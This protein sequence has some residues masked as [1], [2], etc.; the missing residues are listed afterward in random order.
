MDHKYKKFL[1]NTSLI[2]IGNAGSKLLSILL[3]PFYTRWLSVEDYGLT[4]ILSVY[5]TL[6]VSVVSC[7]IAE[8]LFVFP[9]G[10]DESLQKKY[11]SSGITFALLMLV[12]TAIVFILLETITNSLGLHNSFFDNYWLIYGLVST[13]ILQSMSQQIARSL[14]KMFIY[15]S[16]GLI[17][18]GATAIF[19]FLLIPKYG[20]IGFVFSIIL[21]NFTAFLYSFIFSKNYR[22]I[23][24]SFIKK[25]ICVE[26]LRYSIPLIP[27]SIMWWLI[28]AFNRPMMEKSLGLYAVG[29]YAIANKFPSIITML[30]NMIGVSWQNSVLE[31]Y[32]KEGFDKFYDKVFSYVFV[33]FVAAFGIVSLSSEF[34]VELIT[35]SAYYEAWHYIPLLTI[36]VVFANMSGISSNIFS[37]VKQSKYYF[38]STIWGGIATILLNILF[39][40][41]IGLYGACLSVALSFA[42]MWLA[43]LIYSWQF[44][45]LINLRNHIET[46]IISLLI[47]AASFIDQDILRIGSISL[48]L[49]ILLLRNRNMFINLLKK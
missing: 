26:M 28:S 39:I 5:Q 24:F 23:G 8:S 20:V 36:A 10:Q 6:L 19:S 1:R 29:I 9:K 25:D 17:L 12:F 45:K 14:D 21:A 11:I 4:D 41:T 16:T 44:A 2:F 35:D 48:L 30:S 46:F 7:C 37:A 49:V 15:S 40:P 27:N 43:R 32:G 31:E 13:S 3:L 34:L 22:F 42:I 18:T 33:F 38:Y 47:L